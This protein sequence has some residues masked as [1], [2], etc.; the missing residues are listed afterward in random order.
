MDISFDKNTVF[1]VTGGAGFIGSNI[2]EK[3]IEEGYIVRCLDN[4][5]NGRMENIADL[6][7]NERFTFIKGDIRDDGACIGASEGVD[8]IL[9]DA[10]LG[11]VAE[12]MKEPELYEEVNAHGMENMVKAAI[13]NGVKKFVY[14]SSAAVYGDA[15]KRIAKEGEEGTPLS[16]YAKT[17]MEN[18]LTAKKYSKDIDIYGLRYFNVYGKRQ[19]HDSDYSAVIPNFAAKLIKGEPVCINGDGLQTRDFVYVD[20]VVQANLRACLAESHFSGE[21]FNIACGK[22]TSIIDLYRVLSDILGVK[23]EVVFGPAVKGDIRFSCAD[24]SKAVNMLGYKPQFTFD[25][26]IS[27]SVKWYKENV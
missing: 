24:I 16:V 18:E 5:S 3:L 9:H 6:C 10:A 23:E 17:K 20:D 27:S 11:S 7:K 22:E 25:K 19:R 26:G 2:C 13:K 14:A 12:S 1:L 8:F 4:L 15:G 21:A